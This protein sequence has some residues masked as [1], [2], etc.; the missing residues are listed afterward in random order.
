[1]RIIFT[2]RRKPF[3]KVDLKLPYLLIFKIFNMV[4][5]FE[6]L[7]IDDR[8]VTMGRLKNGCGCWGPWFTN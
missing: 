5:E 2:R 8:I 6:I 3:V 4:I 7:E 1:M